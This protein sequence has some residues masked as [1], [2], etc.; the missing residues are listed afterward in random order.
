[1]KKLVIKIC[2]ALFLLTLLG[3]SMFPTHAKAEPVYNPEIVGG[4]E[5]DVRRAAWGMSV[6]EVKNSENMKVAEEGV[7]DEPE[8]YQSYIVAYNHVPCAGSMGYLIYSF[9]EDKLFS[10]TYLF[11]TKEMIFD[12]LRKSSEQVLGPFTKKAVLKSDQSAVLRWDKDETIVFL[13]SEPEENSD[14]GYHCRLSFFQSSAVME[15]KYE[16]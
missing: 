14:Y 8:G 13:V 9:Y 10:A 6:E 16:D 7:Y 5:F 15:G 1:M 12:D 11:F 2:T 3:V 4:P